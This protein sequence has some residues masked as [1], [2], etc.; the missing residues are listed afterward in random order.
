VPAGVA[1]AVGEVD[2]SREGC[3]YGRANANAGSA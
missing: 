3:I 1:V 2:A